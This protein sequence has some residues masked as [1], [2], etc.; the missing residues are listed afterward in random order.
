MRDKTK[1]VIDNGRK[2]AKNRFVFEIVKTLAAKKNL[3]FLSLKNEFPN[4]LQGSTGVVN[5]L[6]FVEDKYFKNSNKRHF[7]KA[8]E[9]LLTSD[10]IKFVVSTEWNKDNVKNI[11]K[12][13][14]KEGLKIDEARN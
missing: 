3:S 4:E 6:E 10:D 14:R 7:L 13:A 5:S 1:Y 2:L 9:I 12:I 8:E 11:V